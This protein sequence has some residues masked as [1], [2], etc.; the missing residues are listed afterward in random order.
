MELRGCVPGPSPTDTVSPLPGHAFPFLNNQG[1]ILLMTTSLASCL[2]ARESSTR[3]TCR[4]QWEAKLFCRSVWYGANAQAAFQALADVEKDRRHDFGGK[5]V[6]RHWSS[7]QM[8]RTMPHH[9]KDYLCRARPYIVLR[10]VGHCASAGARMPH[11]Y[12][13]TYRTLG[14]SPVR[15]FASVSAGPK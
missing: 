3:N 2:A 1:N 5:W 10:V 15:R 13:R 7:A 12:R 11:S 6:S 14:G 8:A 9:C 4:P